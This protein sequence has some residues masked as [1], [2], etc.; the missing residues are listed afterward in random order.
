MAIVHNTLLS[1]VVAV[2]LVLTIVVAI[3]L[4]LIVPFQTYYADNSQE[5]DHIARQLTGYER[6]ANS[7]NE[8]ERIFEAT[9]PQ[10]D[11]LGYYLKGG[12]RAL[13]SAELQAYVRSIIEASRGSLVSTQPI[14]KGERESERMVR[15]NVRMSG[16]TDTLLHVLYRISNGVPV[17]L[18]DEV[19]IRRNKSS[20]TRT[21]GEDDDDTLDVQF[22]LTGFVKESVS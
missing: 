6:I 16:S 2:G 14:V 10:E 13:A 19:L 15:V 11:V 22:T 12:T 3:Y 5:L 9:N 18:T 4:L 1:R 17:L 21:D 8:I 20:L 7:R